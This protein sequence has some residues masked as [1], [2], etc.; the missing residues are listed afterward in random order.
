VPSQAAATLGFLEPLAG[1]F[2]GVPRG[3]RRGGQGAF[4]RLSHQPALQTLEE[5]N[6]ILCEKREGED[7]SGDYTN[8][9][10]TASVP[11]GASNSRACTYW[12]TPSNIPFAAKYMVPVTVQ[13]RKLRRDRAQ[14][15]ANTPNIQR[16]IRMIWGNIQEATALLTALN[17][18]WNQDNRTTLKEVGMCGAGVSLNQPMGLLVGATPDALLMH[19]DGSVEAVEVKNHCPFHPNLTT[20]RSTNRSSNG[21]QNKKSKGKFRV[22]GQ[23]FSP[24][25]GVMPQY[26]PQLMMEMFC[27]GD[28]CQSAILVRQSALDG[29]LIIRIHR[30]D[31]WIEEMMY[32]L[33]RFYGDFVRR[34]KPPPPNFF[35][36]GDDQTRYKSFLESTKQVL[37]SK[38][39]LLAHI[40]NDEIQRASGSF[41]ESNNLFL[42]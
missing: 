23:K 13:A 33:R 8:I 6:L 42:D 11:F 32:W 34:N 21:K 24:V 1:D 39:E 12:T 20:S 31:Q 28:N 38:V 26:L 22:T 37:K 40:P 29:A 4:R 2:L 15:Y 9:D 10:T 19:P 36:Q 16:S 27:V 35:Y 3:L 7:S 5:M 17:Y 14:V 30:D 18:F 41:P 25:D